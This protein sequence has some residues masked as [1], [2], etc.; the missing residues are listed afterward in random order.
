MGPTKGF[1]EFLKINDPHTKHTENNRLCDQDD[2]A[3]SQVILLCQWL[4][5]IL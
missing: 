2:P 1:V 4:A 3:L 5:G